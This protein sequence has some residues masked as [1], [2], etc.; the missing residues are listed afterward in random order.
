MGNDAHVVRLALQSKLLK[1]QLSTRS[2][3]W[4]PISTLVPKYREE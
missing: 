2:P 3:I 4:C 1:T